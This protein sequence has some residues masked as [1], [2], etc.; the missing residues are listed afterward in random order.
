[1]IY[2]LTDKKIPNYR[3]CS[4]CY[5]FQSKTLSRKEVLGYLETCYP[6]YILKNNDCPADIQLITMGES[7]KIKPNDWLVF[8]INS[9]YD[10]PKIIQQLNC[11][12]IQIVTDTPIIKGIDIY[13]T[14]DPSIYHKDKKFNWHHVMYPM[15]IGLKT[16]KPSWPPENIVCISPLKYTCADLLYGKNYSFIQDSF[17]N[18][19]N[20]DVLFHI[21]EPLPMYHDVGIKSRLKYPS[22]KTA[23]RLYQSWFCKAPGIYSPN[24]AMSFIRQSKY[25]FLEAKNLDQ[26]D[27]AVQLLKKD[28]SFFNKMLEVCEQRKEENTYQNIYKQWMQLIK[29]L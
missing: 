12:K 21:R 11:K 22:H 28:K 8:Y 5:L 27:E 15:P 26:L 16:C 3:D 10:S 1:M 17:H 4:D 2:F 14:Y 23:N 6:Y 13:I 29:S 20:E 25:D 9:H 18:N 19:G 7:H 24:P